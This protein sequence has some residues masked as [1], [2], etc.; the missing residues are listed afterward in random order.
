MVQSGLRRRIGIFLGPIILFGVVMG[1][2]CRCR[3][4]EDESETPAT[5]STGEVE[6][7]SDGENGEIDDAIR[8]QARKSYALGQKAFLENN[9]EAAEGYF[10]QAHDLMPHPSTLKMIAEC[11]VA[12]GEIAAAV[13]MMEALLEDEEYANRI[14]LQERIAALRKQ[15]GVLEIETI[16]DGGRIEINSIL[17]AERGHAVV[18]VDPGK[19]TVVVSNQDSRFTREANVAAGQREKLIID[20]SDAMTADADETDGQLENTSDSERIAQIAPASPMGPES[21][22]LPRAFWAAS[23]VAGLGLV[24]GTVFGTMALR[25]QKDYD[26]TPKEGTRDSGRRAAVIADISFGLALGAAVAGT[27]VLIS[28]KRKKKQQKKSKGDVTGVT[29]FPALRRDGAGIAAGV[30]F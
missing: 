29:V 14:Q 16:P 24:S 21:E 8:K 20:T 10:R 26:E 27:I 25:D 2:P 11:Y 7:R 1:T 13:T 4:D 19:V 5:V 23:A 6:S 22:E 9:F 3:A 12:L 17:L 18:N 28:E 15:V 30:S